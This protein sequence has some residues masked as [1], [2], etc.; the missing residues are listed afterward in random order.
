MRLSLAQRANAFVSDLVSSFLKKKADQIAFRAGADDGV[1]NPGGEVWREK[2]FAVQA[3]VERCVSL[4]HINAR[5][6]LC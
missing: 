1:T 4:A 6:Q 3:A 5:R 2:R